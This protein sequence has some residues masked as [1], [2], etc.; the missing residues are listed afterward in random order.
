MTILE[1]G[2]RAG[3]W[4][5]GLVLAGSLCASVALAE[6][7]VRLFIP[8]RD[9]GPLFTIN[10]PVQG[11]RIKQNFRT[12]RVTPEFTMTF[13]TNSLGFR[14][15]EPSPRE[16]A[17]ILFL[18]DSF[19]MGFGV[20][21]G[22]E[23]PALIRA[24]LA[25][26]FGATAAGVV[27]AGMGNNGNGR[28]IK[29]LR[30]EIDRFKPRLVVL[31]AMAND[32]EDNQ[33]E[34]LFSLSDNGTLNELPVK[35][36]A[37]KSLE[38]FLDAIPGLSHSH[39]YGLIR[40]SIAGPLFRAPEG[41]SHAGKDTL[42]AD[43]LTE[44]IIAEAVSICERKGT[45]VFAVLVGLDGDRLNRVQSLFQARR[46]PMYVAPSK[47]ERPELYYRIDGHWN[48]A[49]HAFVADAVFHRLQALGLIHD[50]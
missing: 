24:R 50:R 21:D 42:H 44:R 36:S 35:I 31:Q 41:A 19:T 11:K 48:R 47:T 20:N 4:T 6:V 37:A 18:G 27:N 2:G 28:W 30:T 14:G 12:V 32:F 46:V 10:D 26:T 7:L 3:R 34:A 38:P 39:L 15:P 1:R 43:R 16:A 40:Q 5:N 49:G 9:V 45:P 23:Y 33:R 17:P 25:S 8:V 13:S 29:L 22:E